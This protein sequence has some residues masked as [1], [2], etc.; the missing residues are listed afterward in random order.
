MA[1]DR[2][3][4]YLLVDVDGTLL[5]SRGRLTKR[6]L[7]ALWRAVGAGMTLTLASGRT[8]NSLRRV[9]EGLALPPFHMIANGGAVGLTPGG[10]EVRY[11]AYLDPDH[12]RGVVRDLE[13]EGLSPLVFSHRHPEPPLFHVGPL[14][15]GPHFEAYL[16]RNRAYCRPERDL[17]GSDIPRVVEVAAL[18]R[19]PSFEAASERTL[20]RHGERLRCHSMVL[21]LNDQWGRITEFFA[22]GTSKWQAFAGLFPAGA[23]HP[24]QVIAIGDEANDVEMIRAAG[25]GIAMGNAVPAVQAVARRITADLDHD[26]VALALEAVL[27]E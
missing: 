1:P 9:T 20:R 27:G 13:A 24:E 14:A 2:R 6:T 12:W 17:A 10:A 26:G 4:R 16:G 18:G 5:D 8:Y 11:T 7:D 3:Y 23:A 22:P 15:G 25:L 19:N 21:Y